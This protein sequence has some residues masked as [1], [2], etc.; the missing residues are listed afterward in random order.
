MSLS[1]AEL[2]ELVA[3]VTY[4]PGWEI[5]YHQ[6][7]PEWPADEHMLRIVATVADSTDPERETTLSVWSP[8][9]P[10]QSAQDLYEW[11][12]WRLRRIEVHESREWMRVAGAVWSDPHKDG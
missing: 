8:L 11:I 3:Q 2:A 10:F 7:A 5:T 4:R 1:A 9:P 6:S 12:A